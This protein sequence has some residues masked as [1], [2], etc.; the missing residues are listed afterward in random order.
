MEQWRPPLPRHLV[1]G[2]WNCGLKQ[3]PGVANLLQLP[4]SL[5]ED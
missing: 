1:E 2:V 3:N 4:L 5:F